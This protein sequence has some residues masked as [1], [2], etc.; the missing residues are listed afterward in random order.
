M[1]TDYYY[2]N[3]PDNLPVKGAF[4]L[5]EAPNTKHQYHPKI[6]LIN[7]E[8]LNRDCKYDVINSEAL[9]SVYSSERGA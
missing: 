6:K 1:I 3:L 8:I 9:P 5:T 4:V 7:C 2:Y